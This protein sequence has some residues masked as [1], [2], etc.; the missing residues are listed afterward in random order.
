M[1]PVQVLMQKP[2]LA[3]RHSKGDCRSS[4][5]WGVGTRNM[6]RRGSDADAALALWVLGLG[7]SQSPYIIPPVRSAKRSR[8]S[9]TESLNESL[10]LWH[11]S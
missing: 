5:R 3:I 2:L 7:D 9:R 1:T 10:N 11:I 8:T 4:G 6:K